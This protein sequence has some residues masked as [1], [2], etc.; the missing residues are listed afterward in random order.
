M[1]T[2]INE[3]FI[4]HRLRYR[5]VLKEC[6][7]FVKAKNLKNKVLKPYYKKKLVNWQDITQLK[8]YHLDYANQTVFCGICGKST[9]YGNFP[10]HRK[11]KNHDTFI[12]ASDFHLLIHPSVSEPIC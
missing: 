2:P 1:N 3:Y 6:V 9:T 10:K 7:N 8:K 12:K 11:S 5:N 4:L